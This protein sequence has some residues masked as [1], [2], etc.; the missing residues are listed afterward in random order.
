MKNAFASL[1]ALR[2]RLDELESGTTGI[3]AHVTHTSS[4]TVRVVRSGQ[5]IPDYR[6]YPTTARNPPIGTPGVLIPLRGNQFLFVPAGGAMMP[7]TMWGG[8]S[9]WLAGRYL[10]P[11]QVFGLQAFP[12]PGTQALTANRT[13]GVPFL[14][15]QEVIVDQIS[16]YVGTAVAS[17]NVIVGLYAGSSNGW[18]DTTLLC[19]SANV[20]TDTTGNKY[21]TIPETQLRAGH[22]YWLALVP[23]HA[24]SIYM[25]APALGWISYNAHTHAQPFAGYRDGG[26]FALAAP[27]QAWL[28]AYDS[29]QP[30]VPYLMMR[31]KP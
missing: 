9:R 2:E 10:G 21:A 23:S 4:G 29:T 16:F 24:I 13:Y 1:P 19:Q 30:W 18:A 6:W 28:M 25:F 17:S 11:G 31:R 27:T 26:S 5:S 3:M 14:S 7:I 12:S 8:V 15:P 22:L 20:A